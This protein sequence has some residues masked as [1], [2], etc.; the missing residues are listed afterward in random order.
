MAILFSTGSK[1]L[2]EILG[3]F[4]QRSMLLIVGN[5]GAGKTTLASQICYVNAFN[6]FKCLYI[7]FYEDKDKLFWNMKNLGINFAEIESRGL[8][9]YVKL[10]ALSSVEEVMKIISDIVVKERPR[11]VAIDSINTILEF[12]ERRE[13]QRAILLN[14]FYQLINVIDGLLVAIAELPFG[15]EQVDFGAIEF[16]ADAVVVLKH[17]VEK[18]L[19]T[20][21]LE[22][23]KIRGAPLTIAEIPFSIVEGRGVEVFVSPRPERPASIT[24]TRLKAHEVTEHI[25]GPLYKGDTIFMSI[26]GGSEFHP[27]LLIPLIDIVAENNMKTLLITY[28]Y[29][30]DEI[31]EVFTSMAR[32]LGLNKEVAVKALENHCIIESINP[33]SFSLIQL[34]SHIVDLVKTHNPDFVIFYAIEVLQSI[35]EKPSEYLSIVINL[36]TWLKNQGKLVLRISGHMD[37]K[38]VKKHEAIADVVVKLK[39]K[40]IEKEYK[41]IIISWRRGIPPRIIDLTE[42][43]LLNKIEILSKTLNEI[44]KK[45]LE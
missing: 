43:N 18:G 38:W 41:P 7:S 31:I 27:E 32:N 26:P 25:F 21:I 1:E 44:I 39:H 42:K 30:K 24:M 4:R 16:I 29:S 22:I 20:R 8:L 35:V 33:A 19:I 23:R 15:K 5:P 2:D 45:R 9:I 17:R 3:G 13:I 6:G 40:R 36:L 34:Q 14:F 28:R 37:N 11:V 12:L 10:P